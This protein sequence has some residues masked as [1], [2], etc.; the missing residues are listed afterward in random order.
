MVESQGFPGIVEIL[1]KL[2][3]TTKLRVA[4][5]PLVLRNDQKQGAS[6]LKV[7][8]TILAY[9]RLMLRSRFTK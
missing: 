3:K 2:N 9:F 4:E 5:I 7:G 6:K 8:R 1:V